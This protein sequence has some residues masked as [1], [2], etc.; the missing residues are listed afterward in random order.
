MVKL[1]FSLDLKRLVVVEEGMAVGVAR[2]AVKLSL[3]LDSNCFVVEVEM[4][5]GEG[6]SVNTAAPLGPR[7]ATGEVGMARVM[8]VTPRRKM[9]MTRETQEMSGDTPSFEYSHN[10]KN[11]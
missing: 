2:V 8:E 7:A 10:K 1:S 5:V 4:A 6:V 11:R 3:S 9:P